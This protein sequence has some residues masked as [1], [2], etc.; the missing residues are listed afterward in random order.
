MI[1]IVLI[2]FFIQFL[3]ILPVH[4]LLLEIIYGSEIMP[5]FKFIWIVRQIINIGLVSDV[6]ERLYEKVKVWRK[7]CFRFKKKQK[8]IMTSWHRL[9]FVNFEMA[10]EILKK[11]KH[12]KSNIKRSTSHYY[13][14]YCYQN[15]STLSP[16]I[17]NKRPSK[18]IKLTILHH[19][20]SA[21]TEGPTVLNTLNSN[22]ESSC[23][24]VCQKSHFDTDSFLIGIDNRTSYSMTPN[25]EDL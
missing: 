9:R 3:S 20:A 22:I 18:K 12:R 13:K 16:K 21:S 10:W 2:H 19:F 14:T 6:F 7:I 11:S 17:A 1:I 23:N 8:A 4:L 25:V 15:A 5:I 24:L